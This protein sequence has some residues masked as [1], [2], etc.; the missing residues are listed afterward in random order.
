MTRVKT[1]ADAVASRRSVLI[2]GAGLLAAV[3]LPSATIAVAKAATAISS[4]RKSGDSLMTTITTKD[5]TEIYYRD[6]GNGRI[7]PGAAKSR[8]TSAGTAPSVSPRP[9]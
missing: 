9:F 2:G 5:G 3:G 4:N 6:W 8:V 1:S 7:P